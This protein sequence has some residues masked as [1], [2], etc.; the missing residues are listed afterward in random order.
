M[1]NLDHATAGRAA[2]PTSTGKR[3]TAAGE[4]RSRLSTLIDRSLVPVVIA[5][6]GG[7]G[8]LLAQLFDGG[9]SLFAVTVLYGLAVVAVIGAYYRRLVHTP[10]HRLAE[11]LAT[12]SARD[13]IDLTRRVDAGVGPLRHVVGSI[14]GFHAAC[15]NAIVEVASSASR[16]IPISKE[17]ADSYSFQAQQAGLQRQYSR[18]VASAVDKMQEAA[19]IVYEQVDATNRAIS[20]AK[21]SV[22]SCQSAFRDT[23]ASMN[24]LAEQID[25]ASAKVGELANQSNDIGRIIDVI[26]EIADQ[27]NLLALNAA[28]EAA[29]AGEH[30]RGFAVVAAEVRGLAER[31][32]H[33]TTEVRHVIE[34]IQRDTSQVVKTMG[35]GRALAGRTQ[36]LSVESERELSDIEKRVGDISGITIEIQHAMEQQKA[37]ATET[38]SAADALVGLEDLAPEEGQVSCVSTEDLAKLGA[39]LRSKIKRFVVSVDTWNETL[40]NNRC[41]AAGQSPAER[42]ASSDTD[43]GH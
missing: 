29:R 11:V 26:N 42:R 24:E 1:N 34:C 12:P 38:Q 6:L 5:V 20:E 31:T 10:S 16:L 33:S 41:T 23:G 36:E 30:G 19:T 8:A 39:S 22:A 9:W 32:Q 15:D 27:T 28:I 35:D 43:P 25:Q 4:R 40:R 17:F 37:T 13:H 14:N 18:T 21:S 3:S 7:G 2:Q